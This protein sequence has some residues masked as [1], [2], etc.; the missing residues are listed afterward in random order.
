M[1]LT[2][3]YASGQRISR[4]ITDYTVTNGQFTVSPALPSAPGSGDR[5]WITPGFAVI[6]RELADAVWDE[7]QASHVTAGT[8]GAEMKKATIADAVWD[9]LS[10]GHNVAGSFGKHLRQIKE[11]IVTDESTVNDATPTD[12]SFITALSSAVDDFY[13]DKIFVFIDGA[14]QGQSR[15]IVDYDGTTKTV[16]FDEAFTSAPANGDGFIILAIHQHTITQIAD[17]IWDEAVAGHV[18]AGTF[19]AELSTFDA[20]SDTVDIG[21]VTGTPVTDV[22]DFHAAAVDLSGIMGA[23]FDTNLHSLVDIARI[24]QD[25][26]DLAAIGVEQFVNTIP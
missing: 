21:A 19:G 23:G 16:T 22:T 9:E 5:V 11:G 26:A 12:T 7:D 14:L 3:D 20:S 1:W 10:S 2:V 13:N 18:T 17:G 6:E 8:Y 4:R 15:I 24:S 25:A